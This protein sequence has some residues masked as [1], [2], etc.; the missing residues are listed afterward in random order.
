MISSS[1]DR[2]RRTR[3]GGG[4]SSAPNA[5]KLHDVFHPGRFRGGH[6]D[7]AVLRR[8][9]VGRREQEQLVHMPEGLLHRARIVEAHLGDVRSRRAQR[10]RLFRAPHRPRRYAAFR[11]LRLRLQHASAAARTTRLPMVPVAPVT[12]IVSGMVVAGL[13]GKDDRLQQPFEGSYA[14]EY[15]ALCPIA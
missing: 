4:S 8:V 13:L 5:D 6:G 2:C 15:Y 12:R 9:Q 14:A 3:L 10:L 11:R 7:H 1:A